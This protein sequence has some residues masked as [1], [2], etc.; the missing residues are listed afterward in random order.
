[1]AV[2][3]RIPDELRR[4]SGQRVGT[5]EVKSIRAERREDSSGERALFFVLVL[6]D[7]PQ[8]QDTWPVDN[9]WELRARVQG[10][11][12]ST[13]IEEPWFVVFEPEHPEELDSDDLG[14]QL[15]AD[16]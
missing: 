10:A 13:D 14:E 7:P 6:S 16:D 8:D 3:E 1:M 9:L 11:V 2:L 5:T 12:A 15:D 4:L